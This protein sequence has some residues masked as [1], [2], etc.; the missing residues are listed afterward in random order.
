MLYRGSAEAPEYAVLDADK[1]VTGWTA[2]K[3]EAT[4]L[5]SDDAGLFRVIGLDDGTY[6][7]EETKAPAGYNLLSAPVVV[8]IT[9]ATVNGQNWDS[10]A[11]AD[12]LTALAVTAD[13]EAGSADAATG[14]AAITIANNKGAVLPETGGMGTTILYIAGGVLVLAAVVLLVTKKRMDDR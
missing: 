14:A 8:E 13:G 1:T 9:A 7:L 12:A 4:V 5:V 3:D 11:P 2:S 6:Y 10:F